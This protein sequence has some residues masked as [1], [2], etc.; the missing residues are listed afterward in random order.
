MTRAAA[1]LLVAVFCLGA[2]PAWA[3]PALKVAVSALPLKYFV[4]RIGGSRIGVAV[5]PETRP[6]ERQAARLARAQLLLLA[7]LPGERDWLDRLTQANANLRVVRIFETGEPRDPPRHPVYGP[8]APGETDAIL[9]WLSPARVRVAAG[10]ILDALLALDPAGRPFYTERHAAF[11]AE[12]G[13]LDL[14]LKTLFAGSGGRRAFFAAQV[15]LSAFAEAYGLDLVPLEIGG[16]RPSAA[17]TKKLIE[18]ARRLGIQV[19]LVETGRAR[20]PAGGLAVA[21]LVAGP[22]AARIVP[23]DVWSE[24]WAEGLRRLARV[25]RLA[26]R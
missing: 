4:G 22:A 11:L 9:P 8:V 12:V 19:I 20:A 3:G 1:L 25:V 7:G 18:L 6:D 16:R 24:D 5:L 2:L 14:E 10:K 26:L 17:E 23:V 13:R 21:Q 15:G